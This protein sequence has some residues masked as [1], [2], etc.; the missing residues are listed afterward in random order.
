MTGDIWWCVVTLVLIRGDVVMCWVFWS[1]WTPCCWLRWWPMDPNCW[2]MV[3]VAYE[4]PR[5][6]ARVAKAFIVKF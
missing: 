5:M 2:G 3:G 4:A 6:V 1:S